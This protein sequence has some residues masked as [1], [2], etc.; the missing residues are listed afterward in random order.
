MSKRRSER[1]TRKRKCNTDINYNLFKEINENEENNSSNNWVSGSKLSNYLLHEPVLDWL[2]LYYNTHGLNENINSH[3][4]KKRKIQHTYK[5]PPITPIITPTLNT[6]D[7]AQVINNGFIFENKVCDEIKK[8]FPND[9]ITIYNNKLDVT[10]L[11]YFDL[12]VDSIN[13]G[14]P[15]IF[16]GVL[17]NNYNKTRGVADIIIRSDYINKLVERQVLEEDEIYYNKKPFYIIIDIKFSHMTLCANGY[18]VRN[19]GRFKAY[20]GQLLLYNC[21]LGQIQGYT[22]TKT[23]LLTKSWRI[24]KKNDEKYGFNCFDVLGVIDYTDFDKK[25]I[26]ETNNAIN[27]LRDVRKNGLKWSPL[28]PTRDEMYFNSSNNSDSPWTDIKHEILTKTFDIT[29]IW[30]LGPE[31]RKKALQHNITTWT[32]KRLNCDILNI[33]DGHRRKVIEQILF[34]NNHSNKLILPDKITNNKDDWL[35]EYKTDYFIDFET[36]EDA[37]FNN[38]DTLDVKN[39]KTTTQFIF[40]IG[41]GFFDHELHK[42]TY[43]TF[44]CNCYDLNEEKNI[45]SQFKQFITERTQYIN[46]TRIVNNSSDSFDNS[47]SSNSSD[48][49][50]NNLSDSSNSDNMSNSSNYN[51]HDYKN[52]QEYPTRLF[53]WSKAE[54]TFLNN[55]IERHPELLKL[56]TDDNQEVWI[57]LCELFINEP[58]TI[59]GALCFKLKEIAKAMYNNKQ[60]TTTWNTDIQNGLSAMNYAAKYYTDIKNN[61]T[62]INNKH[63]FDEIIE[64]NEIDCKTLWD[65]TNYLR[66]YYNKN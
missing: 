50:F 15:I 53:H 34:I 21:I 18:T 39:T 40:M 12:T 30:M 23:Y 51:K 19:D 9:T 65:I 7:I 58:I 44:K 17:Y 1:I 38:T 42:W 13:K 2:D 59:K 32:D 36:I 31:H 35:T 10:D 22:H 41:V 62:N 24:D 49:N 27:W 64:Y 45:I 26:H 5:A 4:I 16:Q 56:W 55:A 47:D 46:S 48:S 61:I 52:K 8:M 20:K 54:R 28:E 6:S 66:Q 14:I 3:K 60:I 11:K 63:K 37:F 25:F 29:N 57:D 33:K 43:K